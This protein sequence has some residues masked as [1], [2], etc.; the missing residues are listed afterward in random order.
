M[1]IIQLLLCC[2]IIIESVFVISLTI[3]VSFTS[4]HLMFF[5]HLLWIR[6][7]FRH[8][9]KKSISSWILYFIPKLE[10]YNKQRSQIYLTITKGYR[11]KKKKKQGEREITQL[12][13]DTWK[14]KEHLLSMFLI[15]VTNI[16]N[17]RQCGTDVEN[18]MP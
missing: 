2:S 14:Q 1:S 12:T 17:L 18:I 6:V 11:E 3:V 10:I 7:F 4:L 9:K 16:G 13:K 15:F 8:W 5:K